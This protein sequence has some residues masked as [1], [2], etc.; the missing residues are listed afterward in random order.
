M[1]RESLLDNFISPAYEANCRLFSPFADQLF[2]SLD[3]QKAT[4]SKPLQFKQKRACSQQLK[5]EVF[6]W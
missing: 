6:A 3:L 5:N 4:T 1:N 2:Q